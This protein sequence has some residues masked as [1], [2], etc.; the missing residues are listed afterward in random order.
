MVEGLK[1]EDPEVKAE[2]EKAIKEFSSMY[3]EVPT[4]DLQ[5]I[6]MYRAIKIIGKL[7]GNSKDS[8][9]IDKISDEI[10]KGIYDESNYV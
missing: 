1:A 5:G 10:L 8:E 3:D 6:C 4:S 9:E 7:G 2:I